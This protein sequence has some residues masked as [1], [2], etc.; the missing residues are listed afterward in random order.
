MPDEQPPESTQVGFEAPDAEALVDPRLRRLVDRYAALVGGSIREMEPHLIEL[1]VPADQAAHFRSRRQVK[2]AL[3]LGALEQHPEAE[4]PV[5][6]SAFLEE[7]IDAVRGHGTRRSYGL[8]PPAFA[9]DPQGASLSVPVRGATAGVPS[10]GVF[11]QPLGRLVARVA[12]TAGAVV[13]EHIVESRVFD[14]SAGVPVAEEIAL[15]CADLASGKVA[16]AGR[17]SAAAAATA[18]AR[19]MDEVVRLML[20]DL[21][22]RLAPELARRQA[23][24][25]Q[26]LSVEL[27]RIDRYYQNLL[28]EAAEDH[29]GEVS[30]QKRRAIE[31]EH[32]RRRAEEERRHELRATV[33]PLQLVAFS[34]LAQRAEWEFKATAERHG[35]FAARRLLSGPGVW[36]I[37]CPNCGQVPDELRVCC[38]DHVACAACAN[39]C[40]VCHE[41]FC[42]THG[43]AKCHVDSQPACDAHAH[44]CSS[45]RRRH[46]SAHQGECADGGHSACTACLGS[47]GVCG[48]VIC[49]THA[50]KSLP[51]SP[52][53]S[54]RLCRDC[55]VYCEGGSNE[56]V[57]RDEVVRCA[58]CEKHVCQNHQAVCAVDQQVHCSK[59]LRRA[60]RSRRLT[61]ETHR[62]QCGHE[63]H[64]IFASDEVAPCGTCGTPTC[65]EHGGVCTGDSL[66]HCRRHLAKLNDTESEYGCEKHRSVCHVD[67]RAFTLTGTEPCPVCGLAT[68]QA[69]TKECGWCGRSV[70]APDR[71]A[72][73]RCV[74]CEQL[75]ETAEPA[76][77]VLSAAVRANKGEPPKAKA[78]RTS[79]DATHTIV[80]LD[81]G[82]T[83]KLVFT[84]RHG[85][86]VPDTTMRHW[87]LGRTA[88]S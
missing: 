54:R 80:E 59:H 20:R 86:V 74:T 72:S 17:D 53:G 73:R 37:A 83:R 2:I 40:S 30:P 55:V 45:C 67:K 62:A 25:Q 35:T 87:L 65:A 84:L 22:Q 47:C 7:L 51:D 63:P 61:C 21:E 19:P 10:V 32:G 69:H 81:L 13:E 48:R 77:T 23:D 16:P 8:I 34:I 1:A 29:N 66:R 33:H 12:L 58:S 52:R 14:L 88:R 41:D 18:P 60:D 39:V 43:L 31:A 42:S 3:S 57:G 28:E 9:A 68:C 85:D 70:C 71:R 11:V 79:R 82:W 15:L 36:E 64:V 44:T 4:L 24:A 27:A 26:A 46:C 56:P 50:A 78:W 76:D 6:G 5:V 75:T 38:R 49:A